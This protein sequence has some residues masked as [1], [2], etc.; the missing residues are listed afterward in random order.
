[1]VGLAGGGRERLDGKGKGRA[2]ESDIDDHIAE[3]SA[4][5]GPDEL[6]HRLNRLRE[7]AEEYDVVPHLLSG[8]ETYAREWR[9]VRA[10]LARSGSDAKLLPAFTTLPDPTDVGAGVGRAVWPVS[11][12]GERLSVS[13]GGRDRV[14]AGDSSLSPSHP[15]LGGEDSGSELT[16][17]AGTPVAPVPPRATPPATLSGLFVGGDEARGF[18]EV[19]RV[20]TH[21]GRLVEDPD[22][23][24]WLMKTAK[25]GDEFLSHLQVAVASLQAAVGL[26]IPPTR[27]LD[28]GR[29]TIRAWV[30]ATLLD[31]DIS[32]VSG[33]DL[34]TLQKHQV[35]DWLISN[36]DAHPGQFLRTRDGGIV[37]IDKDQAF[38]YFGRD[39]LS[40]RFHPNGF[41]G[42]A[43][44]V[45]NT[46]WR[47]FSQGRGDILLSDPR[48]GEVG[49]FITRLRGVRRRATR[50]LLRPYA[51]GAAKAG[52]LLS[53]SGDE[54][55]LT[56]Q[57]HVENDVESFLS[58]VIER[59]SRLV[60]DFGSLYQR[61]LDARPDPQPA[62][63]SGAPRLSPQPS[64]RPVEDVRANVIEVPTVMVE[65]T[66]DTA[67][68]V[69]SADRPSAQLD[70]TVALSDITLPQPFLRLHFR[71]DNHLLFR[72]DTRGPSEIFES[73]FAPQQPSMRD[74]EAFILGRSGAFVSTTR[75]PGLHFRVPF[76]T[77]PDVFEYIID[78]P[79]GIEANPTL[80]DHPYTYQDE[81][82]FPGGIRRENIIGVERVWD[83]LTGHPGRTVRGTH[84]YEEFIANPRYD[85]S[86]PNTRIARRASAD[87]SD[88][89]A[90]DSDEDSSGAL[91]PRAGSPVAP[92]P[93][94][95][96]LGGE[97]S[98]DDDSDEDSS[99][100]LTPRAGSPVAP[101]PPHPAL[102]GEDG[103][104]GGE[105]SAAPGPLARLADPGGEARHLIARVW[106][107]LPAGVADARGLTREDVDDSYVEFF[108]RWASRFRNEVELRAGFTSFLLTGDPLVGLEGG[109][110]E[111][112][113]SKGK[114]RATEADINDH[115]AEPP[116]TTRVPLPSIVF[117][118]DDQPSRIP[119]ASEDK[120][121]DP[122]DDLAARQQALGLLAA[123]DVVGLQFAEDKAAGDGWKATVLDHLV[124]WGISSPEQAQADLGTMIT[125]LEQARV[126][127]N[128]KAHEW[129]QEFAGDFERAPESYLNSWERGLRPGGAS[130]KGVLD[131]VEKSTGGYLRSGR[132]AGQDAD[133]I[134]AA[135]I[136][137]QTHLLD[138]KSDG[139]VAAGRPRYG[140]V[141]YARR[142]AGGA[143][144]YGTS[145]FVVKEH[146]KH[147]AL[148]VSADSFAAV[149]GRT[150]TTYSHIGKLLTHS[151]EGQLRRLHQY[152]TS[153]RPGRLTADDGVYFEAQLYTPVRFDRDVA[154]INVDMAEL[155]SIDDETLSSTIAAMQQFADRYGVKLVIRPWTLEVPFGEGSTSVAEDDDG[156]TRLV[157]EI[158]KV[159][160][161]RNAAGSLG[162]DVHVEGGGNGSIGG[163]GAHASGLK[164]ASAVGELIQRKLDVAL[165]ADRVST[166]FVTVLQPTSRGSA[167]RDGVTGPRAEARRRAS[168]RVE[169]RPK[170][171]VSTHVL[172]PFD[173]RSQELSAAQRADLD[174]FAVALVQRARQV[175]ADGGSGLIVTQN[176]GGNGGRFSRGPVVVG[177]K[178][179]TAALN[180]L[181]AQI[182]K[183]PGGTLEPPIWSP[184]ATD[185]PHGELTSKTS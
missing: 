41:Y 60:E 35:F 22:G 114:G 26:P 101:A 65:G 128:F 136:R 149:G 117:G 120:T 50:D 1:M 183:Q 141:D 125:V 66:F 16:P 168:V 170:P 157:R 59:K 53:T 174:R 42:E 31:I 180:Y 20:G 126:T 7:R 11:G 172:M 124:G 164:R 133:R 36:H 28:G 121:D 185:P 162:L 58:A 15:G 139:F 61:A 5:I 93:S 32:A 175:I 110:R 49:E 112:L 113:D 122:A 178:R 37:G 19:R 87:D 134:A 138:P 77:R 160:K 167:L 169:K 70:S 14:S 43:E 73:G 158:V 147:R 118:V 17:K 109:A 3:D 82:S 89:N 111:R 92:A 105:S 56:D 150:T 23:Q 90:D 13:G 2:T 30:D 171:A 96:A 179:A 104:A 159:A 8:D 132:V 55:G 145:F 161:A 44:P 6:V 184:S 144:A 80:E 84:E 102:S 86:A 143:P 115:I 74:F 103:V 135:R 64:T 130:T 57:R 152:A 68:P 131:N 107:E 78:A 97:A 137:I 85:P 91:T 39:I 21:G 154:E 10:A 163:R 67:E 95:P 99:G 140:A 148:F 106:R 33:P 29:F 54:P 12:L 123:G 24:L 46:M 151:A 94:H 173:E 156:V 83:T 88:D 76:N 25:E 129:I 18:R 146:V 40:W 75:N 79:G 127:I 9:V 34:V 72:A 182:E 4:R 181:R 119:S 48:T 155:S 45:Y 100:A 98:S 27:L 38:R 142:T 47:G 108:R 71:T 81:V 153:S 177:T 166:S 51:V 116:D 62:V 176:G 63:A 69:F 52:K 165:P